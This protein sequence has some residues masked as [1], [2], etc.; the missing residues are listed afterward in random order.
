MDQHPVIKDSLAQSCRSA[1]VG[2]INSVRTAVQFSVH[3]YLV[4]HCKSGHVVIARPGVI[5]KPHGIGKLLRQSETSLRITNK[6][7][8]YDFM[9]GY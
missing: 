9:L 3:L 4:G 1:A 2:P 8:Y 6:L 7:Q 5:A